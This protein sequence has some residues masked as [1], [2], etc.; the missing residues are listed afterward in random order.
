MGYLDSSNNA[1]WRTG[2]KL[3]SFREKL[4]DYTEGEFLNFLRELFHPHEHLDDNAAA[5]HLENVTEH[6]IKVTEHPAGTDLLCYP[7]PGVPDTPEGILQEVK[8]WR[9]KN[10][11]PGFKPA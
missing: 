3:I 10:G 4:E 8:E 2:E 11:K 6:F 1:F 5:T 7:R 9:E